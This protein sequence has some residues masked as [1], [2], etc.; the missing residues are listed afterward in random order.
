MTSSKWLAVIVSAIALAVGVAACGGD[1]DTTSGGGGDGGGDLSGTIRIDGSSTVAPLSEAAAELFQEEAPGVKVTVGT[2]G[3]GGG[4]E[5][6]CA[7][8]T[9]ISDASRPIE[10]DEIEACEAKGIEFEEIQVANDALS[11]VVNPDNPI[12]CMTVDQV[13]QIWDRG[14]KVDSWG[15]VKGLETDVGD[16]SMAL[17]GPGTDSGTFDYF[18][19]AINGEEG[20]TR[21]DYNNIGEDDNGVINGVGG[22]QW[23]LGYVPYSYV[24][25]S[26]GKVKPVAIENPDTGECVE[27]TL[28]TVQEGS[29]VPLGRGLFV[30]P[31]GAALQKPEVLAFLNFYI[32]Q[33]TPI[34]EVATFIPLTEAQK[35]E[36][37]EKVD[38]LV[39][40]AGA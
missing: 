1:G 36:A 40:G 10:Q 39:G 11:V 5:K 26:G 18:T 16:A 27:P 31:S 30:Y 34:T 28:E 2:S 21:A 22:D 4:F 12:E 20:V 32:E 29:Y 24:E 19:E 14:S 25:E 9:D 35:E 3:T 7:G 17:Y 8:E 38:S 37:Q 33:N 15:D 6:F 23:A 13:S